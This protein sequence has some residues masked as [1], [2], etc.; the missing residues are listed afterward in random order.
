MDLIGLIARKTI[1]SRYD[2]EKYNAKLWMKILI[3]GSFSG[4]TSEG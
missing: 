3:V 4:S 1:L 2:I